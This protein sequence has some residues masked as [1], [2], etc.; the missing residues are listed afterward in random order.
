MTPEEE[1]YLE[2]LYRNP[3]KAGSF[4]GV[5]K[6]YK[7]IKE[8]G[9][10]RITRKKLKQWLA[11]QET[12]TI[13]RQ[14]KR[15][16][17]RRR[18]IANGI[19][20]QADADL[21]DMALLSR[22]NDGYKYF[23]LVI[24]VFSKRTWT[25]PLKNKAGVTLVDAF[26]SLFQEENIV[27]SRCRTDRGG[28]F[29]NATLQAYFRKIGTRHFVSQNPSTKASVAERCIKTIKTKLYR[30]MSEFQTFR[31]IDALPKVTLAY[32]ETYHRSI[33]MKPSEVNEGN[34][35]E[36][37]RTLYKSEQKPIDPKKS[38][39]LFEI[40]DYVRVSYLKKTFDREYSEKWTGEIFKV[41]GRQ[42]RQ[43]HPVYTIE[44]YAGE[45]VTGTFYQDELQKIIV[46]ENAVYRI[47]KIIRSR[48][49]KGRPKEYLVKWLFYNDQFNSWITE[50]ELQNIPKPINDA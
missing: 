12:Y 32:N 25:H 28:E 20:Y 3:E 21:A 10:F 30:Y 6:L 46:P 48:K 14:A 13:H 11:S 40:N 38:K 17:P 9:R 27:F 34:Q 24:D 26:K 19:F 15:R 45:P 47:E 42:L 8:E 23:L 7:A 18:V 49:R 36:V 31:Y 37:W 2:S 29:V 22:Y 4:S 41:T 44:D 5:D 1:A 33:K 16:Y 43:G 35:S 50:D 39:F